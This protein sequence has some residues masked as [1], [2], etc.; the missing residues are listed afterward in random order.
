MVVGAIAMRCPPGLLHKHFLPGAV[1]SALPCLATRQHP[2]SRGP[3]RVWAST[4]PMAA[5]CSSNMVRAEIGALS[6]KPCALG[7]AR[8]SS[9]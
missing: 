7:H 5:W 9:P 1:A 8:D 4:I 2:Q 3:S 6:L